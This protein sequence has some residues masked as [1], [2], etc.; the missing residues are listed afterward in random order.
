[1]RSPQRRRSVA[2]SCAVAPLPDDMAGGEDSAGAAAAGGADKPEI[3]EALQRLVM[4]NGAAAALAAAA[5][6]VARVARTLLRRARQGCG[7][8]VLAR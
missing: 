7:L 6:L 4:T 1:V 5:R 8:R 3:H 2:L